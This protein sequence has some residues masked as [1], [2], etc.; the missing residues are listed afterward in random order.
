MFRNSSGVTVA[1]DSADSGLGMGIS[2]SSFRVLDTGS[3]LIDSSTSI[4]ILES[5]S[6]EDEGSYY[7]MVEYCCGSVTSQEGVLMFNDDQ[8][9][10]GPRVVLPTASGVQ[11]YTLPL[12]RNFTIPCVMSDL[13]LPEFMPTAPVTEGGANIQFDSPI[14]IF[15]CDGA[16]FRFTVDGKLLF[17]LSLPLSLV[18]LTGLCFALP[19]Y[20]SPSKPCPCRA[21][22]PELP[23]P[24]P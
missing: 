13:S 23:S 17:S 10:A 12:G 20:I 11:T 6:A 21:S 8:T 24:F 3:G 9:I 4:L 14:T 2:G 18:V 19:H 16:F 22:L 5:V 7:C 15:T 1:L